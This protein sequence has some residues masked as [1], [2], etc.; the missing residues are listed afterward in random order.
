MYNM[1]EPSFFR[2]N[3]TGAAYEI[4]I[5]VITQ[6]FNKSWN[7]IFVYVLLLWGYLYGIT[8]TGLDPGLTSIICSIL[9]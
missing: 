4:L 3:I 1:K 8:L 6:H 7:N 5:F 9:L 2:T